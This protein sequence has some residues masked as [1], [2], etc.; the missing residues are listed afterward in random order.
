LSRCEGRPA[1]SV[2]ALEPPHRLPRIAS[3][4]A[5]GDRPQR[6]SGSD[7]VGLAG[8]CTLGA[9]REDAPGEHRDE[10]G[11]EEKPNEHV[12]A[13]LANTCSPV[14]PKV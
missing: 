6:V 10:K 4:A 12:F 5:S 9:V 8:P 1:E 11:N 3:V 14:N 2:L 13:M 7:A